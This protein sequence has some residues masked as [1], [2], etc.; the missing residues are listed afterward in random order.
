MMA[1]RALASVAKGA[2]D[3]QDVYRRVLASCS[4]PVILH[5]LGEAFDPMLRGYWGTSDIGKAM[6]VCLEIIDENRAR[7]DGIKISLLDAQREIEMRR[8]L[9]AG[10]RMYTGDDFHYS[11]LI[12]GD[13]QGY[14]DALLGIFDAIAPVVSTALQ[15]LDRGEMETYRKL[16]DSTVPLSRHIFEA[17]TYF[18]KTGLVLLAYLNGHQNHFRMLGGQ[19]SMRSVPHMAKLFMLA[20]GAALLREPEAAV[21][22][23][24]KVLSLAGVP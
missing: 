6:D 19:E 23:M 15:A 21:H 11:E 2:G 4:R 9:P 14:S 24:E 8:R 13:E 5:W 16:M 12:A 20:D 17:P 1:S 7:I 10:V 3:Y 18:Y 22:R